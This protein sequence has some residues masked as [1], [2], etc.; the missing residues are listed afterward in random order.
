MRLILVLVLVLRLE[1]WM[2]WFGTAGTD[3]RVT[4]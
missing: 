1:V 2:G 3:W 4:E